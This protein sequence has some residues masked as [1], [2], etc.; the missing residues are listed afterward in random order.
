MHQGKVT[1]VDAGLHAVAAHNEIEVAGRV[2]DPGI[3][4]AVVFLIG[5]RAVAR[6]DRADDRD[7]A[8]HIAAEEA[9]F[10][11]ALRGGVE[12]TQQIVRGRVQDL[13]Q[14]CH[15]GGVRGALSAL[16]FS[17]GLLSHAQQGSKLRLAHVLL[18]SALP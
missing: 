4:L 3:L 18:L 2:L 6:L 5:Q 10:G 8:V 7:Q 16:P 14:L 17:H 11:L 9:L 12:Q 13:R 1:I 15:G